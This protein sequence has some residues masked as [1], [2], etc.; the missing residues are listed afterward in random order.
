MGA[1]IASIAWPPSSA[2]APGAGTGRSTIA[3]ADARA[4]LSFSL[5]NRESTWYT[6][7]GGRHALR[8]R[9]GAHY[10]W[11]LL[12]RPRRPCGHAR[13]DVRRRGPRGEQAPGV[14]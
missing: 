9:S 2:A 7:T 10:H 6:S 1:A 5:S 3:P 8:D 13:P 11:T 4:V 14:Q 12:S